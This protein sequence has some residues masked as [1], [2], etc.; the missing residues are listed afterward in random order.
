MS[1]TALLALFC[2]VSSFAFAQKVGKPIW[3]PP[4][5]TSDD[6]LPKA[7]VPRL[8]VGD[9]QLA[10]VKVV[11]EQTELEN[12]KSHFGGE[13]GHQGDA[14]DYLSWLC[15]RGTDE[16]GPWVLWLMSGEMDAGTVGSFQWRR[17]PDDANFDNRC[18]AVTD[19]SSKVALPIRL[20]LGLSET[21]L[22]KILGPPTARRGQ[23]LLYVHDHDETANGQQYT[24]LNTV[25]VIIRNGA[26]YAVEVLKVSIS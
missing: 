13:I 19:S 18:P 25:F 22:L 7:T 11:L 6:A 26:V 8:M 15:Y 9:L 21:N 1:R 17:I 23:T 20:R 14:G 3:K 24:V 5:I 10:D 12:I 2:T 16:E 4:R